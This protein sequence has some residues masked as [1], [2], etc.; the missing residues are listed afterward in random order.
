MLEVANFRTCRKGLFCYSIAVFLRR[1][2]CSGCNDNA[3]GLYFVAV[4]DSNFA[5]TGSCDL[6]WEK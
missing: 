2:C 5:L 6:P 1:I 3:L 4:A